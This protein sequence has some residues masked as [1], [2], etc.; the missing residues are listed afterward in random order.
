MNADKI[1]LIHNPSAVD[2]A[3]TYRSSGG[4]GFKYDLPAEFVDLIVAKNRGG[5][6]GTIPAKFWPSFT[7]FEEAT[8][9]EIEQIRAAEEAKRRRPRA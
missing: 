9:E 6:T 4:E 1:V 5:Q 2:R 7:L 3:E 8:P